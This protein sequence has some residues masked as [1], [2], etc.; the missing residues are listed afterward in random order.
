GGDGVAMQFAFPAGAAAGAS[1]ARKRGTGPG[2]ITCGGCGDA[3]RNRP[4]D[5]SGRALVWRQ[6]VV[7]ARCG[8]AGSCRTAAATFVSIASAQKAGGDE[9]GALPFSA[10]SR[11]VCE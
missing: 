10:D 5:S 8:R 6:A 2:G 7:D 9:D 1:D 4:Q 3:T 11:V